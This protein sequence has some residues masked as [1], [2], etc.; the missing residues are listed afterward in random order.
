MKKILLTTL[1]F[2]FIIGLKA[3]E[4]NFKTLNNTSKVSGFGVR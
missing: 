1:F 3:Q 2:F 4:D